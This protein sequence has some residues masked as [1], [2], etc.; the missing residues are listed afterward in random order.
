M[1][2]IQL[3]DDTALLV[4]EQIQNGR[5]P[6]ADAIVRAGLAA[7]S[8][9]RDKVLALH[10]ALVEGEESG[11]AKPGSFDRARDRVRELAVSRRSR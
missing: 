1:R 2:S 4:D 5:A 11:V 6:S 8:R 9:E 7:L 3:A 10:E